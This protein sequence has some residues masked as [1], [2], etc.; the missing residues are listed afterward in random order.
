MPG[1]AQKAHTFKYIRYTQLK[2]ILE[3]NGYQ[4]EFYQELTVLFRIP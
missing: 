4:V 2:I 3:E 1:S